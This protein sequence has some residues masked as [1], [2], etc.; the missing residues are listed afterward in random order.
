MLGERVCG[1]A[2]GCTSAE[3]FLRVPGR[4]MAPS[5][6]PRPGSSGSRAAR[7][8]HGRGWPP[9]PAICKVRRARKVGETYNRIIFSPRLV[10]EKATVEN[11]VCPKPPPSPCPQRQL[12]FFARRVPQKLAAPC[13]RLRD[14]CVQA[15]STCTG[16]LIILSSCSRDTCMHARAHT[17]EE[18]S[19]L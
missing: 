10:P 2:H 13:A 19:W 3:F 11:P 12:Q 9:G 5:R 18:W 14:A 15:S 17:M 7:A 4:R 6:L 8:P 1:R 16:P